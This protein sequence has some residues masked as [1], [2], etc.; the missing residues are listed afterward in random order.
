MKRLRCYYTGPTSNHFACARRR[1]RK[2]R[3]AS[4]R[5]CKG[6]SCYV[7]CT[8]NH[9]FL[10]YLS[11]RCIRS[12]LQSDLRT[13][14]DST[15]LDSTRLD[16]THQRMCGR[17][18]R[19]SRAADCSAH[20]S[21]PCFFAASCRIAS[22]IAFGVSG[23]RKKSSTSRLDEEQHDAGKKSFSETFQGRLENSKLRRTNE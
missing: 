12:K 11:I 9:L 1:R 15:R 10:W 2:R 3:N 5:N 17:R 7:T 14:L 16:S 23:K 13:R 19:T 21:S 20:C 8:A 18:R 6:G 4:A 22:S